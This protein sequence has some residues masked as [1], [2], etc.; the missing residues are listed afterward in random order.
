VTQEETVN[1]LLSRLGVKHGGTVPNFEALLK[2]R[3]EGGVPVQSE[4]LLVH[5]V[6]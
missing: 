2:V 4:L 1:E 5:T 3:I 6:K